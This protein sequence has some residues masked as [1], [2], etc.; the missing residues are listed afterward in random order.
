MWISRCL[1]RP[2][3][4]G[5]LVVGLAVAVACP[6]LG[7]EI[8]RNSAKECAICHIHWV[9]AFDRSGPREQPMQT[10]LEREA[11]SGDM[12]LSCHDGSVV[13]SR[14]KIWSTSHH[15]TDTKP[16]SAVRIPTDVFPLD[17]EGRMT[18]A[19]CHTAHAAPNTSD[20]RT[21]VF[22]RRPNVD[23]S[24][25]LACHPET[26]GLI[27][28]PHDLRRSSPDVTNPR[29]ETAGESG[30]CG[31]CHL[32]HGTG[33]TQGS[34]VFGQATAGDFGVSLCT[35]CHRQGACAGTRVPDSVSHPHVPLVNRFD[36]AGPDFMPTFA[37]QGE[38]SPTGGITCL[39]CHNPHV[40][41]SGRGVFLRPTAR[42][43]LCIDCHG[44]EALWRF[45]YFHHTHRTP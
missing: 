9:D 32:I 26:K 7:E 18:C 17:S 41:S 14:F 35:C 30:P 6:L 11:G 34:R 39:T 12:C 44:L 22:L 16:S 25:C 8:L 3:G 10:I 15:G 28:T 5:L 19:T 31:M 21:V 36:A 1:P 23:S 20:I 37:I 33:Q 29:G 38:R 4:M 40:G 24:L 43:R 45:L 2:D 13:D 42:P 27:G